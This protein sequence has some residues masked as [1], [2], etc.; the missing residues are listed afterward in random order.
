MMFLSALFSFNRDGV[1]IEDELE[2]HHLEQLMYW[3]QVHQPPP[4]NLYTIRS[5]EFS[6]P[7]PVRKDQLRKPGLLDLEEFK[8]TLTKVIGTQVDENQ[9]DSLFT[10][11]TG[12]V[13]FDRTLTT[14]ITLLFS[15]PSDM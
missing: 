15:L 9:L 13:N 6:I 11:V 4:L 14:L 1:R 2:L 5:S 10:K 12:S 3:F 8:D 7:V